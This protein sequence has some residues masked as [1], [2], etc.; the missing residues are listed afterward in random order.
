[1]G[2]FIRADHSAL[3]LA[4]RARRAPVQMLGT[5]AAILQERIELPVGIPK[6]SSTGDLFFAK[7]PRGELWRRPLVKA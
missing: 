3:R 1:V 2:G 6:V 7:Q 4:S 5:T